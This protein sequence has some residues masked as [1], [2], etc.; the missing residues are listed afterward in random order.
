MQRDLWL[1]GVC[2]AAVAAV[3]APSA[4]AQEAPDSPQTFRDALDSHYAETRALW[5]EIERF[6]I[7]PKY[8][9]PPRPPKGPDANALAALEDRANALRDELKTLKSQLRD[10]FRNNPR[11]HAE[12][13]VDGVDPTDERWWSRYNENIARMLAELNKKKLALRNAPTKPCGGQT[14]PP[15]VQDRTPPPPPSTPA[16]PMPREAMTYP[17]NIPQIPAGPVCQKDKDELVLAAGAARENANFGANNTS[18]YA[19]EMRDRHA[20]GHA[21]AAEV[22]AA[23]ARFAAQEALR[24]Q[25]EAAWQAALALQVVPCPPPGEETPTQ[26]VT[27][28]LPSPVG[29]P[30]TDGEPVQPP[31]YAPDKR[32]SIGVELGVRWMDDLST[33]GMGKY[34][35][36]SGD[37]G[38]IVDTEVDQLEGGSMSLDIPVRPWGGITVKAEY[39]E[40]DDSA[41]FSQMAPT[42]D[43]YGFGL[44]LEDP[45]AGT[46]FF[47]GDQWDVEAHA[48]QEVRQVQFEAGYYYIPGTDTV[49]RIDNWTRNRRDGRDDPKSMFDTRFGA[50]VIYEEF[51]EEGDAWGEFSFPGTDFRVNNEMRYGINERLVGLRLEGEASTAITPDWDIYL[52][53]EGALAQ[54]RLDAYVWQRVTCDFCGPGLQLVEQRVEREDEGAVFLGEIKA[55]LRWR[56][57]WGA[58]DAFGGLRYRS[59]RTTLE[60]PLFPTPDHRFFRDE[61]KADP[62]AGVSATFRF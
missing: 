42:T 35:D 49:M 10:F 48:T 5:G 31:V 60:L 26:P 16:P 28:E 7:Q 4:R 50:G 59:E 8:C 1:L 13:L 34:V 15:Q 58:I 53:L 55:G 45:V 57:D 61:D 14:P 52:A 3:A 9:P 41:A 17:V 24:L 39:Y 27:P 62:F 33:W 38:L 20:A 11:L 36:A 56:F 23:E 32:V 12:F 19:G 54:R 37:E 40:G 21:T 46:G 6:P 18:V 29:L 30:S 2:V 47:V 22:Q 25:A 44:L 51:D 43:E